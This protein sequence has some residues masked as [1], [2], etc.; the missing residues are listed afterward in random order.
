MSGI[1]RMT[2]MKI[3]S[4]AE[5]TG[6]SLPAG[7]GPAPP[8]G[9]LHEAHPRIG[10]VPEAFVLQTR[11]TRTAGRQRIPV[12]RIARLVFV[13]S[14]LAALAA[15]AAAAAGRMWVGFHHDPSFR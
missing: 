2:S 1:F 7:V 6:G 13:L 8:A 12:R 5:T 15:P 3:A 14:A 4:Q 9:S 11:R 10:G